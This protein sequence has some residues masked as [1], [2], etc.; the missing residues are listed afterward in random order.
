MAPVPV[1]LLLLLLPSLELIWRQHP[2]VWLASRHARLDRRWIAYDRTA[3]PD[4]RS[5][6]VAAIREGSSGIG[7]RWSG[8]GRWSDLV[9]ARSLTVLHAECLLWQFGW[10]TVVL[11]QLYGEE[12][13]ARG[14]WL[15][16]SSLFHCAISLSLISVQ[17]CKSSLAD[18]FFFI[19]ELTLLIYF[20]AVRI[21]TVWRIGLP[22]K[23]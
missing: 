7:G 12:E 8:S 18:R 1:L 15:T 21:K 22:F 23:H 16:F 6:A 2:A 13:T 14:R 17:Q 4:V 11:H 20:N 3:G 5:P 9:D 19:D 10:L